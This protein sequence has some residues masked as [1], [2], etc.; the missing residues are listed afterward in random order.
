VTREGILERLRQTAVAAVS[1]LLGLPA[2][3]LV[4]L[5]VIGLPLAVVG[6]GL[7]LLLVA[8]PGT[9]LLTRTHRV[10]SGAVLGEQIVAEYAEDGGSSVVARPFVGLRDPVRFRDAGFLVF[11][12]T[13]G[14]ALS[15]LPVALLL[16][17][18]RFLALAVTDGAATWVLWV[19]L[20]ATLLAL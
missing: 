6:V 1:A 16:D 8:V 13:A 4:V 10:L 14:A 2:I 15:W 9:A 11:S 3:V 20:A 17:P 5:S 12:A 7:V 18:V 19:L